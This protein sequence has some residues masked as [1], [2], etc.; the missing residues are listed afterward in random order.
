[1]M[2]TIRNRICTEIVTFFLS[3]FLFLPSLSAQETTGAPSKSCLWK[4]ESEKNTVYLLGSIHVLR[5]A[6]YPLK[7]PIEDAFDDV[8]RV[9]FEIHLDS[10]EMMSTQMMIL[11]K[12]MFDD[13][14]NLQNSI[15]STTYDRMRM[16]FEDFGISLGQMNRF[17]PWFA[18]LTLTTLTMQK[19]GFD[20]MYGIDRYFFQKAKQTGKKISALETVGDQIQLLDE[21]SK[22]NPKDLILQTLTEL[23]F[24]GKE[25]D[26]LV[27]SWESGDTRNLENMVLRSFREYPEIYCK[28]IFQRNMEWLPKI[29]YF[30]TLEENVLVI[31]G[32]GHLLGEEGLISSLRQEGYTVNQR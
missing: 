13:D 4:I 2:T 24:L 16:K 31:V 5:K 11:S 6:N 29:Q 17:K 20:P 26:A 7:K 23:D 3:I 14:M 12:G 22:M 1:M 21:L 8:R 15:D 18:A 27:A 9:V 10:A 19:L 32:A 25:I 30:F 28:F